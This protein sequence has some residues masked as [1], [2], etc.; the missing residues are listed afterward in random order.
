MKR[1]FVTVVGIVL[2]VAAAPALAAT[3]MYV[4]DFSGWS[5]AAGAHS[6][7]DFETLPDVAPSVAGTPITAS[8]NYTAQG[9]TFS[10]NADLLINGNAVTGFNLE[11]TAPVGV[12]VYIDAVLVAAASA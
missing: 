7:I 6:T 8:F 10:P 9:A 3:T 12:E 11:A 1:L 4:N 2:C 5:A